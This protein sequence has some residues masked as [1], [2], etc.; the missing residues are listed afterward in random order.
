MSS[1][2]KVTASSSR[3]R[4][5]GREL[6]RPRYALLPKISLKLPHS[7]ATEI[8]LILHLLE[9]VTSLLWE[10][11]AYGSSRWASVRFDEGLM[12]RFGTPGGTC[13]L[14]EKV[15]VPEVIAL[16]VEAKDWKEAIRIGGNLLLGVGGVQPR[17]L[18]AMIEMVTSMGPYIVLAPG[19]AISH[20]RPEDGANRVCLGLARLKNSVLFGHRDNDPVDLIFAFAGIDAESHVQLLADLA[21]ILGEPERVTQIRRARSVAEVRSLLIG[22]GDGDGRNA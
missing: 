19:I 13:E 2:I 18:D 22:R 17:Y 7:L 5:S 9:Q 11:Q 3:D 21:E 10:K 16:D 8:S 4:L 15:L 1:E 20:A 12:L 6:K 14:I